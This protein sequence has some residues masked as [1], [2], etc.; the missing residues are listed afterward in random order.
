MNALRI[1]ILLILTSCATHG[2]KATIRSFPEGAAVLVRFDNGTSKSIGTTPLSIDQTELI[3]NGSVGTLVLEKS[4]YGARE[5]HFVPSPNHSTNL[6][7]NLEKLNE[8]GTGTLSS[9]GSNEEL[10]VKLVKATHLIGRKKLNEASA[11]LQQLSM[12]FPHLAVVHDLMGNVAYLRHDLKGALSHYKKSLSI[13]PSGA[14]T[15]EI[16]TKISSMIGQNENEDK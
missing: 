4:G 5:L 3:S 7:V 16:V 15:R 2:N 9:T 6:S 12:N 11:I 14:E 1:L 13:N 10:A 8:G